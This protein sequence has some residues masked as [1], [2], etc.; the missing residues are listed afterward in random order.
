MTS[1]SVW[2]A[3]AMA[4]LLLAFAS[5]ASAEPNLCPPGAGPGQCSGP[6]GLAVDTET[7]LLYVADQGNNRI[8]VF[9]SDGTSVTSIGA[10]QLSSP[11]W[12]AVDNNAGSPSRHD[13]YVSTADTGGPLVKKFKPDGELI[14]AESFGKAGEGPCEFTPNGPIAGGPGGD[15]YVADV[16]ESGADN[17]VNRV[18]RFDSSGKCLGEVV[19]F[20]GNKVKIGGFAVDASGNLYVTVN[21]EGGVLRKYSPAGA[22]LYELDKGTESEGLAVDGA[23]NVFAKQR[24]AEIVGGRVDFFTEYSPSGV[25]LKR[26]GYSVGGG[27]LFV[28]ALAAYSSADGDLFASEGTAGIRYVALPPP[29]PVVLQG[30]CEVKEGTLG[31]AKATLRAEVNPEGKATTAHFQY[32]SDADFQANIAAGESGFGGAHPAGSTPESESIGADFKLHEANGVA[33]LVPETKYH[34]RVIAT[35]ADA[36]AG[37]LGEEG[38]FTSRPPLEI[39]TTTVSGVDTEAATL[40]AAVNPLG[41]ST[42]GYFEYVEEATYLKDT[43][44]L[45]PGHGFDH[46]SKAPDVDAGEEALDFGAG[47]SFTLRSSHLS[48]LEPATSYAFR[49]VATDVKISPEGKEI[50]GPTRG[51][52]TFGPNTGALPDSRAWELV[53]P[54]QKNSAEVAVPGLAGGVAETRVVRIQAAAGSG[55]AITYTSFT[56]F[57]NPESAPS[58]SQYLSKRGASGWGTE[59]ISPFGFKS[60]VLV[61]PYSGFSADLGFGVVKVTDPVLA[62]GCPEGFESFYLRDNT[63]G[64]L[65]CLTPEAP[66]VPIGRRICFVYAGASK[67][68]SRAF[69]AANAPYAGAP[70]GESFEYNLYEWSAAGGLRVVSVLPG[71]GEAA[72]PTQGTNFGARVGASGG[73]ENCQVGQSILRHVISADG[74]KAFWT[75]RPNPTKAEE[76]PPSRLLVRINGSET[77]Q[78][79]ANQ[80]GSDKAGGRGVFWAASADGSVAYFTDTAKLIKN[81]KAETGAPGL[82]RYELGN[83]EPLADLSKGIRANVQGVVG[84]SDDGSYL[85]FVAKGVLSGEEENGTG[86]RA[87][88]GKNNLYLYHEGKT[89]FIATLAPEDANDWE[90]QPK[91]LSARVSPDG[92]HLAFVSIEAEALAGYDNTI[93]GGE[94][95]HLNGD[96]ELVESPLCSQ[97]FLYDA[98]A[99][100]LTCASCNPSGAR[101]LGPTLLPGWTNPYEGPRYLSDDGSRFFF[102]SLDALSTADENGKRDVYEFERSGAGSCTS[103]NPAFDPAAGGCHFLISSGK[104]TDE[105]F[106][107]DASAD[108]RDAFFST[109]STLVGWD[110]NENYDVYDAR[111]GGGFPEPVEEPICQGEA[112]K[113]APGTAPAFSPPPRYEGPGNQVQKPKKHKSKK[114]KKKSKHKAKKRQARAG[115][116][117]RAG[118]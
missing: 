104:S 49:V 96:G 18:E 72:V 33:D 57:G 65:R 12:V 56:S 48:G 71:A 51:F 11:A 89:S 95:C 93:A 115:H 1:K 68:G 43:E 63:T 8:D 38:S 85:Y 24:G 55:E 15:V 112:C 98:E 3:M 58:T 60:E 87:T 91:A 27:S 7:G 39:G 102:E 29:G 69:F 73:L 77:V 111:E 13:I 88:E 53:S 17:F 32:I 113:G 117:G 2:G 83:A 6:G 94:H 101:P 14:A 41:L 118:R 19:L 37:V 34:C 90:S 62:P 4:L 97:A 28:P 76:N 116:T 50:V 52:R 26:F 114:H 44:E 5:T 75:Y 36:P 92:R 47:E 84:A 20:E 110:T 86:E 23:G 109:R 35:N 9:E 100:T 16:F 61:P 10:G 67:D 40:N 64:T 105:S 66:S 59:S 42:S 22:L 25:T 21:G 46:A 70:E 74:S 31:N 81:S 99:D 80:G 78:L 107:I 82:Y 54:G 30:A 79:D 45:G 103:E 106:L 108:G